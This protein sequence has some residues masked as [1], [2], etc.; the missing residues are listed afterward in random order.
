MDESVVRHLDA[1]ARILT[2]QDMA[3][4]ILRGCLV[5][6]A[7]AGAFRDAAG[8]T[9][10]LGAAIVG[11]GRALS[12]PASEFHGWTEEEDCFITS[13]YRRYGCTVWQDNDSGNFTREQIAARIAAL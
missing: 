11:S 4:A 7:C 9:C 1:P 6:G 2:P 12:S 10:A 3:D 5:T 13:Y 8:N